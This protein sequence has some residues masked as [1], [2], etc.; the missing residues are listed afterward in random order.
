[1]LRPLTSTGIWDV[2]VHVALNFPRHWDAKLNE[3]PKEL[4]MLLP[5]LLLLLLLLYV[6]TT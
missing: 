5:L 4:L 6:L 2:N 1:M 3:L